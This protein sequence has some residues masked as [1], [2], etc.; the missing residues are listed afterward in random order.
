MYV[1]ASEQ[2]GPFYDLGSVMRSEPC[3]HGEIVSSSHW[4][5]RAAYWYKPMGDLPSA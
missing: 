5:C 3:E 4:S 1:V 2:S